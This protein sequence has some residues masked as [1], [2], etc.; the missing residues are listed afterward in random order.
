M[1]ALAYILTTQKKL[2][3]ETANTRL[4]QLLLPAVEAGPEKLVVH[5]LVEILLKQWHPLMVD[6]THWLRRCQ[7]CRAV[8]H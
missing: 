6:T 5:R 4:L 7:T 3:T 1:S 2:H 8:L